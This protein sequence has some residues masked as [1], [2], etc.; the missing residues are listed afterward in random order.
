MRD[1]KKLVHGIVWVVAACLCASPLLAQQEGKASR[2]G[3][4]AA[5]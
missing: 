4:S 1:W 3:I 2:A 5:S